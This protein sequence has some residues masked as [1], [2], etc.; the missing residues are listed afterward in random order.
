M[1]WQQSWAGMDH[2]VGAP[3]G[4]E[5]GEDAGHDEGVGAERPENGACWNGIC[6]VN[7]DT[8]TECSGPAEG[9]LLCH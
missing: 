7:G 6:S 3:H 8:T 5:C 9:V 1:A 2:A 4:G